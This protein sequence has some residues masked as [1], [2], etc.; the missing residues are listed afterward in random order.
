[1]ITFNFLYIL[2]A[3]FEKYLDDGDYAPLKTRLQEQC[4][5]DAGLADL[6]T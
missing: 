5:L 2:S 4:L 3:E 6:V 1:M